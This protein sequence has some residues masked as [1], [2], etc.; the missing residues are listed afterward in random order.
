MALSSTV[1]EISTEECACCSILQWTLHHV[2]FIPEDNIGFNVSDVDR[3][4]NLTQEIEGN[5]S[6]WTSIM[7]KVDLT[8]C[9]KLGMKYGSGRIWCLFFCHHDT[10]GSL[11]VK[12]VTNLSGAESSLRQKIFCERK[13][14][15]KRHCD[16]RSEGGL[17]IATLQIILQPSVT[18]RWIVSV[19]SAKIYVDAM[20][21]LVV[22]PHW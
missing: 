2:L 17:G 13:E 10:S 22:L 18:L 7:H 11:E 1:V 20:H 6:K 12:M 5:L 9:W 21:F 3:N 16:S 15:A 4:L 8:T 14:K 19:D